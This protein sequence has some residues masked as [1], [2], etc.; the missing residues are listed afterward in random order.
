MTHRSPAW[1][2][3]KTT[4]AASARMPVSVHDAK[5][6]FFAPMQGR[7]PP[8]TQ[9]RRGRVAR[10]EPINRAAVAK[11]KTH[12]IGGEFRPEA[13]GVV[14]D[15]RPG[16]PR[17]QNFRQCVGSTHVTW[18]MD[19]G[20]FAGNQSADRIKRAENEVRRMGYEFLIPQGSR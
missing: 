1:R 3:H 4:S 10:G 12:P 20:I 2:G 5:E 17:I 8:G 9:D 7:R 13:W 11:W 16:D 18:L 19:S 15:D 14:F 6:S